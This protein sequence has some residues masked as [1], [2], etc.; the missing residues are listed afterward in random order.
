MRPR[1]GPLIQDTL[2]AGVTATAMYANR[3]G[4][5]KRHEVF[6][7]GKRIGVF[8]CVGELQYPGD[9]VAV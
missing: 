7:A 3:S 1:G 9:R 6:F 8:G 2:P 4:S 5:T